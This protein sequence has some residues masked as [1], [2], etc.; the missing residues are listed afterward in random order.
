[1]GWGMKFRVSDD[2][3]VEVLGKDGKERRDIQGGESEEEGD[4]G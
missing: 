3:G 1:M 2:K 4:G